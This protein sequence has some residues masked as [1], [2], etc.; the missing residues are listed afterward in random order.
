MAAYAALFVTGTIP[1]FTGEYNMFNFLLTLGNAQD[2]DADE[3]DLMPDEIREA[4]AKAQQAAKE[5]QLKQLGEQLLQARVTEKSHREA[6]LQRIRDA[7]RVIENQKKKLD[8]IEHAKKYAVE[9]SNYI[10]YLVEIGM[11][12]SRSFA[13]NQYQD[14]VKLS[15]IPTSWQPSSKPT[16][17]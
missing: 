4:M 3:L 2:Q 14:F 12:S 5:L 9:T 13:H 7:K 15:V 6:A 8:A 10:P 1:F 16:G 17:T 11:V